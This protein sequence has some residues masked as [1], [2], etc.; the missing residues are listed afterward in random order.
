MVNHRDTRL[1]VAMW[2]AVASAMWRVCPAS[3]SVSAQ[4]ETDLPT[5]FAA[6]AAAVRQYPATSAIIRS[7]TLGSRTGWRTIDATS[8]LTDSRC[9]CES[10]TSHAD[11]LMPYG[12]V[13]TQFPSDIRWLLDGLGVL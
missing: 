13:S 6:L 11:R 8:Y 4:L 9:D 5:R 10:F 3:T 1:W 2:V 7:P 12:Y